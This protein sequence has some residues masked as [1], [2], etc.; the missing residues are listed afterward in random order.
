MSFQ[1]CKISKKLIEKWYNQGKRL[2][3]NN[4]LKL[5]E[6]SCKRAASKQGKTF[7]FKKCSK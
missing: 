7:I 4:R 5:K 3:H 2:L 6:K 1:K